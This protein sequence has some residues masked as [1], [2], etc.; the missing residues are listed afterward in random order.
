MKPFVFAPLRLR[1]F[2]Y[3]CA[4]VRNATC[5]RSRRNQIEKIF[6]RWPEV[7]RIRGE[8]EAS[9]KR[10]GHHSLSSYESDSLGDVPCTSLSNNPL[11][12]QC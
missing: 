12:I 11:K 4:A 9:R 1:A 5:L 7:Q 6:K 8:F 10:V 3:R 2:H